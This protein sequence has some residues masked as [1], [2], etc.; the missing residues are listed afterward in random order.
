MCIMCELRKVVDS[1]S[2]LFKVQIVNR[3]EALCF[4]PI[5]KKE[6]RRVSR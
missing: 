3:K 5:T 6:V 4:M 1:I 2:K